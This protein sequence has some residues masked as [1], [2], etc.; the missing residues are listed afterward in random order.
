[1]I[2][3]PS[4][5]DDRRALSADGAS[6]MLSLVRST[7]RQLREGYRAGRTAPDLPSGGSLR[8]V[9]I[10]GMGGSGVVGD[11]IRSLY[12]GRLP[13][14]IVAV[15]GY[16]LPEFCG[17]DTVAL[18]VSFSGDT[19]ETLAAYA[20][21]V[22]RGCRVVAVSAGGE[23]AA[24][25]GEDQVP[26][27]TL[28]GNVPV[29]RAALGFAAGVPIGLLEAMGLIPPAADEV[30]R[31]AARLEEMASRLGPEVSVGENQAKSLAGWIGDRTPVI[32]GSQGIADAAA[33]RWKTQMNENAKVPAFSSV[34]PELD[35][36]E[37]EGWSEGTGGSF[38]GIAL[39]H[40]GEH[41]QVGPRV[42]ATIEAIQASG[43]EV[44]ELHG[45]GFAL[46]E[47]LFSL[48]MVGDFASTYLGILRGVDPLA[49]PVLTKL[50]E[51]LRR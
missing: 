40:R 42:A 44:R 2:A 28:P 21:A 24:R 50:K 12:A 19:E 5:L 11:I 48:I 10:C 8:S 18:A 41:P 35:H 51:R 26:H 32:W 33:V 4:V 9:A 20:D 45:S 23:L 14:P 1:M 39:R 6:T 49:I 17:R 47:A 30:E 27:V 25:A 38:V 36:N 7:G 29:P 46:L 13:L 43:L 22:D 34:L 3:D 15:K 37:V 16:E 31:T